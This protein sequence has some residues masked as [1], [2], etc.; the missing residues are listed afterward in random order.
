[1]EAEIQSADTRLMQADGLAFVLLDR[2]Q[3]ESYHVG[4]VWLEWTST[5]E[6]QRA[7]RGFYPDFS[8]ISDELRAKL[9]SS[10]DEWFKFFPRNAVP[11]RFERDIYAQEL[12]ERKTQVLTKTY[13][14]KDTERSRLDGRCF[15]PPGRDHVPEGFYSWNEKSP[16]EHNCSSWAIFIVNH[17]K[18]DQQFIACA[19]PKRLKFVKEAVW[20][21]KI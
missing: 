8:K 18:G 16:E 12:R 5:V 2:T 4:H 14:I 17:A 9:Q 6:R 11:G 20:G 19:R 3:D 7:F 13:A 15:I 21:I 10:T 1:M